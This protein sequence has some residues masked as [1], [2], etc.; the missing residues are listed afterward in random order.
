MIIIFLCIE[1]MKKPKIPKKEILED[2]IEYD[3][4]NK[5]IV[6]EPEPEP[7]LTDEDME[8]IPKKEDLV[9]ITDNEK[10]FNEQLD[11]YENIQYPKV[12]EYVQTLKTNYYIRID[13]TG[14]DFDE[15]SNLIRAQLDFA[16]PLRPIAKVLEGGDFRGLLMDGREGVIPFRRWSPWKQIDPVALKDE[17]LILTGSTEFP[18]SYFGRVFLF[19]SDDN[20][21]KFLENPKKYINE[22]PQVPQNYRISIIGPPQSGKK[23]IA[24][25]LSQIYHWK[26]INME[27]IFDAVKEYQKNWEEPELNSVYTRRVH[28]SANEFK[29][30]LANA[31]K[32]PSERKPD[33]FV[34]KIVFML[35]SMGIPLDKK[36]T[37]EQFFAFRKYHR[38]KLAHMFN[39][40][41]E[42]YVLI[43]LYD[44]S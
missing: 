41:K 13:T 8:K 17:F 26:I 44:I 9:E 24:N 6:P 42:T 39:R 18:A 38:G 37:K 15:I 5:P 29:E 4:E 20:R 19:V 22:P 21:K 12:M 33:N 1:L 3:E 23:T 27:E 35:D 11:Y 40:I 34:S 16:N 43:Y 7:E 32:K 10:I 25:M 14:L 28:F 36:K 2:E 31:S 30:V